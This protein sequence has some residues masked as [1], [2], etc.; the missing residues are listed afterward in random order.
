MG[1][2]GQ[3]QYICDEVKS[4]EMLLIINKAWE[5]RETIKADLREALK[6]IT[7]RSLQNAELVAEYL[8]ANKS[9]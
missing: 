9:K 4:D 7:Q 3:T 1:L 5:N 2:L 8:D 6:K